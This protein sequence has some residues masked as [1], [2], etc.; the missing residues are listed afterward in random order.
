MDSLNR[1]NKE[2]SHDLR[3]DPSEDDL[4]REKEFCQ[5]KQN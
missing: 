4:G 2:M 5:S 3:F 1:I